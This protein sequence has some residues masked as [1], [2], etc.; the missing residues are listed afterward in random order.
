MSQAGRVSLVLL[1]MN[2]VVVTSAAFGSASGDLDR[3][4]TLCHVKTM[5]VNQAAVAA[6]LNHGDTP[7]ACPSVDPRF[8]NNGDGTVTDNLT[9]LVWLRH[10]ECLDRLIWDSALRA[11]AELA[12]R[13]GACGLSDGSVAG[14]WRVPT[15]EELQS[16]I[17]YSRL[18]PAIPE[19]SPLVATNGSPYW[20]SSTSVADANRAWS[21]NFYDG[22]VLTGLKISNRYVRAVRDQR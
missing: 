15:V 5:E 18:A 6:H 3:S 19:D 9:G 7:G 20:S 8:V 2:V 21:V 11:A 4:V 1:V 16:L 14:D 17:D 13:V 12:D 10:G 22:S